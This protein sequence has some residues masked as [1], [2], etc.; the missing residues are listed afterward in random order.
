MTITHLPHHQLQPSPLNPRKHQRSPEQIAALAGS[1][2][3][4]GVLQNLV[5][6]PVNGHYEIAAGEG[7]WR[8]V[9]HLIDEGKADGNFELP[10]VVRELSDEEVIEIGLIENTQR[11]DLTPMDEAR[12]FLALVDMQA[13]GGGKAAAAK[14]IERIAERINRTRRYVQQR[15]KLARDLAPEWAELLEAGH[16]KLSVARVLASVPAKDQREIYD[17]FAFT[18]DG[19]IDPQRVQAMQP[20]DIFSD[21]LRPMKTALFDVDLADLETV[22]IEGDLYALDTAAFDKLQKERAA[23]LTKELRAAAKA[24][25][26]AF[27]DEVDWLDNRKYEQ[28]KIDGTPDATAGAVM[29]KAYDGAIELYRGMLKTAAAVK[30]EARDNARKIE[31]T[32]KAKAKKLPA[33]GTP[34]PEVR[35]DPRV[36]AVATYL[37]KDLKS[38]AAVALFSMVTGHGK[39]IAWVHDDFDAT[40]AAQNVPAKLSDEKLLAWCLAQPQ[41]KLNAILA[42]TNL[43]DVDRVEMIKKPSA[44]EQL[45]FDH[46]GATLPDELALP[47]GQANNAK[48]AGLKRTASKSKPKAKTKKG[49]K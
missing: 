9:T 36:D 17:E 12:A 41:S 1:I 20:H 49:K 47:K 13:A 33:V 4:D 5:V 43:V 8:A 14:A 11:H 27:F 35:T 42:A 26:I 38:R 37:A 3:K 24:G 46:C 21:D 32:K 30:A 16:L 22:E 40:A 15:V 10:V 45:L 34:A 25:E 29:V 7:R 39:G 44:V 48:A 6:R 19:K 31:A 18:G 2:A 28:Q 23:K